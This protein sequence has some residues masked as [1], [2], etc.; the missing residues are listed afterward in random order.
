[1]QNKNIIKGFIGVMPMAGE[2]LRFKSHGYTKPKPLIL[3]NN[4]P[5]FINA[6]RTFPKKLKWIYIINKKIDKI[7]IEKKYLKL[8]HKKIF[9]TLNKKT[10]GQASTVYK[11]L[12]YIKNNDAIIVHSCDL[13]FDINFSVLKKKLK[14]N[15]ILVFTAKGT[16][17]HL[18]NHR[19]FSWVK[20]YKNKYKISLK[21]N[22]K[23]RKQSKVLIGTFAF[24]NKK[25]MKKLLEYSF[26]KKAKINKEYYMDTLTLLAEKIGYK[27][28][29][30]VV[31][32]YNSWGSHKE[33]KNYKEKND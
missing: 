11:S 21:K 12:K 2:G 10:S 25:I 32:N 15:D 1:M 27:L 26:K 7:K 19:Q 24:K 16:K 9:L 3:V 17:Y 8:L 5:M 22:F 14:Q 20:K 30:V 4:I 33:L 23:A 28:N 13:S 31:K 18:K 6:S 29:E